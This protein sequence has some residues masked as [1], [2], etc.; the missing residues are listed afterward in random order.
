V[1]VIVV[2]DDLI[3]TPAYR[4]NTVF[5]FYNQVWILLALAGSALVALMIREAARAFAATPSTPLELPGRRA[6]SRYGLA[7][8]ALVLLA[9]L[10]YPAMAT[11]PRLAQ[12]FTPGTRS[13]TLDALTWMESGTVPVLGNAEYSEIAYAGDAAAIDWFLANVSGTPVIAEA[14]IGPYRCH[15]SRI[16]AATGLP[17]IIGWE[18]HQQQQRYPET[19]PPRVDDVRTLYTSTDAAE[20]TSILRRYNV[21]YVVVGDLERLY[22]IANN[23]CTPTGSEAGI[24]AF[25]NMLGTTLEVVHS[26]SGTT[27]YRV[28]P[29][30]AA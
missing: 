5:K 18:R 9:S 14:A 27:I 28:L 19:L 3:G 23:E 10:A 16:S 24:A 20:K 11:G 15:G 22:P 1:E 2:A 4:M 30:A 12:R 13:G 21:E 6:W 17:T 26:S 29:I 25:E 7:A 8:S